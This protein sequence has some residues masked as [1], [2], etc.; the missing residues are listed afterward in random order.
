MI[1]QGLVTFLKAAPGLAALVGG[2]VFPQ[3]APQ[4]QT[5]PRVLYQ[6]LTEQRKHSLQGAAGF[7]VVRLQLDAQGRG[8]AS[9][10]DAKAVEEQL[11][12]CLDGF[13]G[14]WGNFRV[15]FCFLED[16]PDD[17]VPPAS[18]DEAGV[19]DVGVVIRAGF[20]EAIPPLP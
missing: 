11:R 17:Y 2:G 3:H 1:E 19:D 16:S 4:G 9:Y 18:A 7:T 14:L 6:V 20:D 13:R 10:A 5:F 12:Q 15:Q 8:P